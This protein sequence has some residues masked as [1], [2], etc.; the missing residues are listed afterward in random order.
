MWMALHDLTDDEL[1][2]R[3]ASL[4]AR[5]RRATATLIAHLAELESRNLPRAWGFR[6]LYG[7]C[8]HVLHLSEF[9][10]YARM[11][12]ARVVRRFPVVLAMLSEGLLH[13]TAV[14]ELAPHLGNE[15]HL[16][17]LGGAIHCSR[18]EI[19]TRLAG[20][21]PKGDVR[22][23]VRRVPEPTPSAAPAAPPI[24]SAASGPGIAETAMEPAP[25]TGSAP[26]EPSGAEASSSAAPPDPGPALVLAS[27]DS[28]PATASRRRT[29]RVDPLSADAY[30]VR[31]TARGATVKLLR[32]ARDLLG[33]AVP[34]GEMD[35]IVRRALELLVHDLLQKRAGIG[36]QPRWSP[37][38]ASASRTV[39]AGVR[40]TVWARDGGR[41]AFVGTGGQRC[42]ETR[43]IEFHHMKPWAAGGL[44]T[45]E[46]IALRCRAH[47]QH[48]ADVFFAPIR[49]ARGA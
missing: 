46:N 12:A 48:E 4:N 8:R 3:I 17:L 14:C 33:H 42:E 5:E 37:P 18:A 32:Q 38:P 35:P 29:D 31:F 22:A 16:A 49:E 40:R 10:S 7:Y 26:A 27:D 15:D 47:N 24:E 19:K 20:W 25:S 9:E 11:E 44:P 6:S 39:P 13:M 45:A 23:S 30:A 21:F 36:R 43:F 1:V 28:N 41:C 2:D 34:D